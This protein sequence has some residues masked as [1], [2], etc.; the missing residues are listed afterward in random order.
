M[1]KFIVS[2]RAMTAMRVGSSMCLRPTARSR[3]STR[4][5]ARYRNI[6]PNVLNLSFDDGA[7]TWWYL[8]W[9]A[10]SAHAF[11]A[12]TDILNYAGLPTKRGPKAPMLW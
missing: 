7:A 8:D 1:R 11:P 3:E 4:Q 12:T 2:R 9:A 10:E 5:I 6:S